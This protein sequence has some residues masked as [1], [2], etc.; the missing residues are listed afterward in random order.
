MFGASHNREAG[1]Q[2]V[3]YAFARGYLIERK[4]EG[5]EGGEGERTIMA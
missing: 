4:A 3:P 5:E 2:D 1:S